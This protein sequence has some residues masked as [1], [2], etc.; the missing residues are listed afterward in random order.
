MHFTPT[1]S[2]IAAALA[3][4]SVASPTRRQSPSDPVVFQTP[5]FSAPV[6]GTIMSAGQSTALEIGSAEWNH[7]HPG[8]TP[9]G[10]YMLAS[11][12]DNSSLNST[13]QFGEY[14]Y[15]FGNFL[16]TNDQGLPPMSTPPPPTTL[17]MPDLGAQYVGQ[18]V[19]LASIETIFGC[20]PNGY[21]EY[22][23]DWVQ[24]YYTD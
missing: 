19:Y 1:L 14:L 13:Y 2:L 21:T 20:P 6:D 18:K 16:F 12:P 8:Y 5:E 15:F 9:L 3:A 4:S 7:C 17:T 10:L 11:E 23:W 22:V 24:M